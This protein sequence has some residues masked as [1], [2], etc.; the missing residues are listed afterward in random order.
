MSNKLDI[1]ING[2]RTRGDGRKTAAHPSRKPRRFGRRRT[3]GI[4]LWDLGF[5]VSGG[6]LPFVDPDAE[7]SI[8]GGLATLTLAYYDQIQSLIFA[9]DQSEWKTAF[10]QID[11]TYR[12]YGTNF[13]HPSFPFAISYKGTGY[14]MD[15][16]EVFDGTTFRPNGAESSDEFRVITNTHVFH[17]IRANVIGGNRIT[18]VLDY[19]ADE[20]AFTPSKS[21]DVF[22][23]PALIDA[24]LSSVHGVVLDLG[25]IVIYFISDSLDALRFIYPR[26][27]T[28]NYLEGDILWDR[29]IEANSDLAHYQAAWEVTEYWKANYGLR[30]GREIY[31]NPTTTFEELDPADYANGTLYPEPPT[32][33]PLES[34]ETLRAEFNPTTPLAGALVGI[35]KKGSEYYYFW[36]N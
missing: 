32:M 28:Y 15:Q 16:P 35:I 29:S 19:A 9:V 10:K 1:Y 23:V 36:Q 4:R 3:G 8:E 2:K 12:D 25:D 5:L 14:T 30:A 27:S 13:G 20:V 11:D 22:V 31:D 26:D 6:N 7:E 21:M 18:A 33:P 17:Q 24:T 34:T